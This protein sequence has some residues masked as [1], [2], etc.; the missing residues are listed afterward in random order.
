[1][2]LSMMIKTH[3]ANLEEPRKIQDRTRNIRKCLQC[4]T[5][6][7][8][9]S[10]RNYKNYSEMKNFTAGRRRSYTVPPSTT[11]LSSFRR[12]ANSLVS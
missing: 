5:I 9:W 6:M 8:I 1:M 11:F 10:L 2:I 3:K 12:F 7:R 4:N